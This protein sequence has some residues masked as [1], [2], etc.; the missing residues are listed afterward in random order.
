MVHRPIGH[1]LDHLPSWYNPNAHCPF[2]EGAPGHD[3]EGYYAFKHMVRELID[4]KILSFRDMG[5]NVKDNHL[6]LHGNLTVNAIE[7]AFDGVVVEKVDNVKTPL[8]AFHA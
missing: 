8:A 1:P 3:L 6:P 5:T 2:H 4:S 7:D